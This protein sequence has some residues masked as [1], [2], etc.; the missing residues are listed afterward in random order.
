MT[1]LLASNVKFWPRT[2]YVGGLTKPMEIVDIA[3]LLRDFG[4]KGDY[5]VQN[6]KKSSGTRESDVADYYEPEI[7]EIGEIAEQIPEEINLKLEWR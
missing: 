2:T 1:V 6:F 3:E 7:S 5:L 4:Y